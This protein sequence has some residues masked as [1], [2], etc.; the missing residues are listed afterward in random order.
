[1]EQSNSW[2]K[3]F[4]EFYKVHY[5][6]HKCPSPVHIQSRIIWIRAPIPLREDPF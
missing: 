6:I 1:M 3:K 5:R 2:V 4:L